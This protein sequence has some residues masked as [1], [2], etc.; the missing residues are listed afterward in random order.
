VDHLFGEGTVG[1]I[2]GIL[3]DS[4]GYLHQSSPLL[5]P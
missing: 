2:Y 4:F 5:R 1:H 3:S